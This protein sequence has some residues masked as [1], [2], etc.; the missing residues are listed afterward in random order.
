ML[1]TGM[2]TAVGVSNIS[3]VYLY[4][5]DMERSLAFYRDMLGIPLEGDEHW[6]EATF[7]GG[8]RFALHTAHE[9]IGELS[10]GTVNI[11]LEVEDAGA[12]A[13]LLRE[14]GTDV[15]DAVSDSWGTA[16]DVVD[17][18]GYIVSLFQRPA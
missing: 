18:D 12:A 8:T 15:R 7:P 4:V 5:R 6:A 10:S 9:G 1:R 3:V 14:R 17:P 11:S 16:V 13:A 2:A